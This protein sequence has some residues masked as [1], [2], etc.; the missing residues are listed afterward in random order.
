[1]T[2]F[3]CFSYA[4]ALNCYQFAVYLEV[5]EPKGYREWVILI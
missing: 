1:M 5:A 4:C 2:K 3:V